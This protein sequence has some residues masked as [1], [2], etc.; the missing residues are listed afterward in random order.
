ME[1]A[2]AVLFLWIALMF[3]LPLVVIAVVLYGAFRVLAPTKRKHPEDLPSDLFDGNK[4]TLPKEEAKAA[5]ED[6][7]E[8]YRSSIRRR[9][10]TVLERMNAFFNIQ[11][12]Y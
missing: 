4:E 11:K 2:S 10:A 8:T 12:R 7:K 6:F 9:F 1:M 3:C 5:K